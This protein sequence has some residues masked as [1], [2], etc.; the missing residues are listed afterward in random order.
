MRVAARGLF[1]TGNAFSRSAVRS[2]LACGQIPLAEADE[3]PRADHG[4]APHP[5]LALPT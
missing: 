2:A 4:E 1:Q 3:Y 5:H